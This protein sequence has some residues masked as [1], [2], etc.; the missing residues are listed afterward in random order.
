MLLLFCLFGAGICFVEPAGSAFCSNPQ[1]L[2]PLT[3]NGPLIADFCHVS[4][5]VFLYHLH[6]PVHSWN[7]LPSLSTSC[8]CFL[9]LWYFPNCA[10]EYLVRV[11]YIHTHTRR[12]ISTC[13]GWGEREMV[14]DYIPWPIKFG[15]GSFVCS[16]L[17]GPV[18]PEMNKSLCTIWELT[19]FIM[20]LFC[21]VFF[22]LV[23]VNSA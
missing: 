14:W 16:C 2:F 1:S 15:K 10:L 23:T 18:V 13:V 22:N 17:S 8:C 5:K 19:L 9:K 7:L 4:S 21:F 3:H 6:S 12:Y 20:K 11:L